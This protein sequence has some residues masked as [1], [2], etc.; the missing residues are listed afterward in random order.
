MSAGLAA[1]VR[2]YVD[3]RMQILRR[4]LCEQLGERE[5]RRGERRDHEA[6]LIQTEVDFVAQPEWD[7]PGRE[8]G[9]RRARRLPHFPELARLARGSD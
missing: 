8:F 6:A 5:M 1:D 3:L 4:H 2:T 7:L 9:M